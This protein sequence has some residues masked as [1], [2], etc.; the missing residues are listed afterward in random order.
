MRPAGEPV[1]ATLTSMLA[2][3]FGRRLKWQAHVVEVLTV[4]LPPELLNE[5]SI[6]PVRR[7]MLTLY[8]SAAATAYD[9]QQRLA[10][11]LAREVNPNPGPEIKSVRF[12]VGSPRERDRR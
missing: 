7:G 1:G 8:V 5:I 12:A 2:G 9:L 4:H 6:G 11:R 3:G 10:E